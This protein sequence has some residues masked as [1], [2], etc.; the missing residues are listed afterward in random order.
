MVAATS[1]SGGNGTR[2]PVVPQGPHRAIEQLL[3]VLGEGQRGLDLVEADRFPL[4]TGVGNVVD[5]SAR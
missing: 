2:C 5:E 3:V 1:V 4:P